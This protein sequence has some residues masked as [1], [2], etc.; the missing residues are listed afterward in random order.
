MSYTP[1]Q[2]GAGAT[3]DA[4]L[5]ATAATPNDGKDAGTSPAAAH[6]QPSGARSWRSTAPGDT[7][8]HVDKLPE[9]AGADI[10]GNVPQAHEPWPARDWHGVAELAPESYP[11]TVPERSPIDGTAVHNGRENAHVAAQAAP[12]VYRAGS[13]GA[14]PSRPAQLVTWLYSRPWDKLIADHPADMAKIEQGPPIASRPFRASGDI[15]DAIPSPGGS[16]AAPGMTPAGSQPNTVRLLPQ[17][18]D[19]LAL[20]DGGPAAGVYADPA[21]AAVAS[22][23][24]TFR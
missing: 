5:P 14:D 20:N 21:R 7:P 24:R 1:A 18:W 23:G 3:P 11:V 12:A 6:G 19:E 9:L 2:V 8:N 16:Q 10:A 4:H 15:P 22:R 13:T 17:P